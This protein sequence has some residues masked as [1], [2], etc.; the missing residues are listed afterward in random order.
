MYLE[1]T[2][3][4]VYQQLFLTNCIINMT[5]HGDGSILRHLSALCNKRNYCIQVD[6]YLFVWEHVRLSIGFTVLHI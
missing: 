4:I 5:R 3:Y 1:K 2:L 6:V